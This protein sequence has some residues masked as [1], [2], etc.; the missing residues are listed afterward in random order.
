MLRCDLILLVY[1]CQ[2]N[3]HAINRFRP[4]YAHPRRAGVSLILA[5]S[6][7]AEIIFQPGDT[8]LFYGNS[9]VEWL[10]EHGKLWALVQLAHSEKKLHFRSFAWTGDEVGY[11][12][13]PEGYE[14]HMKSLLAQWP[15]RS[16]VVGFGMNE[17]FAGAAG[18]KDFRAQLGAY[19]DQLARLH[20]GAKLVLLA[21]TVEDGFSGQ[22]SAARNRDVAAYAQAIGDAAKARGALFVDLFA[23]SRGAYASRARRHRP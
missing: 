19:L 6:A 9:M 16:V 15:A 21:P 8:V 23:A 2:E 1:N 20:P 17:S 13:R 22:D 7:C 4:I 11:Q 3:P 10:G 5:T 14:E 18:L 12:L